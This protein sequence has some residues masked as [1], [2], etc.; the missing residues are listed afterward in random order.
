MT[1]RKRRSRGSEEVS[2]QPATPLHGHHGGRHGGR[3]RAAPER[4][5][6]YWIYGRH[7]VA[8]AL[9]NPDR[10]CRRLMGTAEALAALGKAGALP[11]ADLP[12]ETVMRE[13]ID[14]VL[15]RG[16]VHQGLALEAAPFE[17]RRLDVLSVKGET[18]APPIAVALDQVTDPRNV[19]AVLRAAA[20]FGARAVILPD[21][22]APHESGALAKAASGALETVP[23]VRVANLARAL[24][25]IKEMGY[26]CVGLDAHAGQTLADAAAGGT[27]TLLVL[28]A[29]GEGL[30]RL[31]AERCDFL[32]RLPIS[33]AVESLNVAAAAAV[34]L[35]ALTTEGRESE[36]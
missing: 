11:R 35:Y 16:A 9:G 18:V 15:P 2:G 34:A 31:T 8:A 28:G 23:M 17:E 20:A 13:E 7:A 30:R 3:R 14:R 32:V 25:E 10:R 5:D 29:E 19:G 1:S 27:P 33:G 24:G 26:W 12:P 22:H 36:E 6:A 4:P 21:R